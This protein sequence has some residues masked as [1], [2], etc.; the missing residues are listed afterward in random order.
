M[1]I[2]FKLRNFKFLILLPFK[3]DDYSFQFGKWDTWPGQYFSKQSNS[4]IGIW[5][6]VT[7]SVT[8]F[9]STFCLH[10]SVGTCIFSSPCS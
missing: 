3:W 7:R 9:Y 10:H 5:Y 1:A 8:L 6:G 4:Q 2:F